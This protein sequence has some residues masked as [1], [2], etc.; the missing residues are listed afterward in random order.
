MSPFVWTNCSMA[1]AVASLHHSPL[2]VSRRSPLTGSSPIEHG[3]VAR[4]RARATGSK[5]NVDVIM[6]TSGPNVSD[7]VP[8]SGCAGV[9]GHARLGSAGE[10]DM[11]R[12]AMLG[13]VS[14]G[15]AGAFLRRSAGPA[16]MGMAGT[17]GPPGRL[18]TVENLGRGVLGGGGAVPK[19]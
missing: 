4:H 8:R 3:D 18:L 1:F 12:R 7:R 16:P 15:V 10:H 9:C 17:A 13:I 6:S 11:N 2:K 5:L 19:V 14:V